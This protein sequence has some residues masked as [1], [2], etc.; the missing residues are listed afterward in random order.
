M[1]FIYAFAQLLIKY[2]GGRSV[3]RWYHSKCVSAFVREANKVRVVY[4]SS[5][6]CMSFPDS[7]TNQAASNNKS[8]FSHSAGG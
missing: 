5:R 3:W 2:L 7:L 4:L 6:A 1:C 8:L